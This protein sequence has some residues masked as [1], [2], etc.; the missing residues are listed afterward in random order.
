M[1][2]TVFRETVLNVTGKSFA[3]SLNVNSLVVSHVLIAG[4]LPQK[5]LRPDIILQNSLKYVK[6]V[7]CVDHLSFVLNVPVVAPDLPIGVRLHQF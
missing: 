7:S 3:D 2:I 4:G 6:D 5:G 1:T